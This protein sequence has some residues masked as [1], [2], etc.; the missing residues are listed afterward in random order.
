[1][2]KE[3]QKK[4]DRVIDFI[5]K[6]RLMAEDPFFSTRLLARTEDYF[7]G[8]KKNIDINPFRIR[9]QPVFAIAII[10]LGIFI[11]V[12]SG[13]RLSTEKQKES[14]SERIGRIEQYANESF[15]TEIKSPV[16]EQLLSK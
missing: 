16:E 8:N 2:D 6:D 3:T 7:S 12:F 15:I 13:N 4:I 1:M 10:V 11:G 9:L 14:D 5:E